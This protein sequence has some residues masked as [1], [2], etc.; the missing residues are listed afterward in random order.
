MP[1]VLCQVSDLRPMVIPVLEAEE[2]VEVKEDEED[3][4]EDLVEVTLVAKIALADLA[5]LDLPVAL[6]DTVEMEVMVVVAVDLADQD[7]E[8]VAERL[9]RIRGSAR[10]TMP[11]SSMTMAMRSCQTPLMANSWLM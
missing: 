7:E 11:K 10:P 6:V 9:K 8:V 4:A 2:V 3:L 1:L 5:L